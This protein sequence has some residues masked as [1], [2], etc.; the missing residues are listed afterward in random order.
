MFKICVDL[1]K[2]QHDTLRICVTSWIQ[3]SLLAENKKDHE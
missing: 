2:T 3:G 1:V